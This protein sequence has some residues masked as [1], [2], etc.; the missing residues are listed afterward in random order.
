MACYKGTCGKDTCGRGTYRHEPPDQVIS[1]GVLL[2]VQVRGVELGGAEDL[3]H[4]VEGLH[5]GIGTV[6]LGRINYV[7]DLEHRCT[8]RVSTGRMTGVV[9]CSAVQLIAIINLWL[10][11]HECALACAE[12]MCKQKLT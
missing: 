4:A 10:N 11:T 6:L 5:H 12:H 3:Q 1:D 9:G 2:H 8:L 7:D